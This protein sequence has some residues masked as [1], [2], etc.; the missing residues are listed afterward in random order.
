MII[1]L[2][3]GLGNQLFQ[4]ATAYAISTDAKLPLALDTNWYT[5]THTDTSRPFVLDCFMINTRIAT[6]REILDAKY[7]HGYFSKIIR[8]V[9]YK[10]LRQHILDF[11]PKLAK[12]LYKNTYLDGFF[13]SEKY[14]THHRDT[15]L[16]IFTLQEKCITPIYK[17]TLTKI[18]G[19][20]GVSLHIRR[21]DYISSNH[22]NAYHG[23]CALSYYE[24]AMMYIR[25]YTEKP[26]I[27]IFSDDI[28]W[29]KENLQISLP[30]T[31]ISDTN[32][33]TAP[34]E[35]KLMSRCKHNIIANSTFSWW[36]AW[37]NQNPDKIVIAPK[38]WTNKTPDPHPNIIPNTWIRM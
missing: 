34:Q 37:L 14:F 18:T 22:T 30:H 26:H 25:D 3:G 4:Y 36:G 2:T 9:Q 11:N 33:L 19:T 7:P 17:D 31:F 10:I 16:S 1:K 24:N 27:Y 21:G 28:K 38:K 8:Y 23:T 32:S 12:T 5:N 13:Q 6:T 15:L 35:L 20:E 29:V